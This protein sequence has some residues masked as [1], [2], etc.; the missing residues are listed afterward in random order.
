MLQM[1]LEA[2]KGILR[3]DSTIDSA[4]RARLIALWRTGE[5]Q[6]TAVTPSAQA[7]PSQILRRGEAANR[8]GVSLRT[9]DLLAT[10][11]VL[12]KVRF[13]G[14][15]RACGF[16]STDVSGLIDTDNNKQSARSE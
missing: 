13:P 7:G 2:A 9:V 14:R 8:L 4:T 16:R 3:M 10:Q 5:K 11:G 15:K 1:T 12:Q 6:S